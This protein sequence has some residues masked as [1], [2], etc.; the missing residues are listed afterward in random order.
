MIERSNLS[1]HEL[2]VDLLGVMSKLRYMFLILLLGS[3]SAKA[4][5][6]LVVTEQAPPLQFVVNNEVAGISTEIVK[7]VLKQA[8]W[9]VEILIYPWARSFD[10]AKKRKNTL[11]YSMMRNAER[12][13]D[14]HWIGKIGHFQL[15]FVAL[16]DNHDISISSLEDAKK[17]IIGTLRDD[18]THHFLTQ[19]HFDDKTQLLLRSELSEIL[20]LFFKRK[21]DTF[22]VDLELLCPLAQQYGYD[23]DKIKMLLPIPELAGDVYLGANIDS[24]IEDVAHLKKAFQIIKAKPQYQHGFSGG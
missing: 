5:E 24:D 6:W 22:V 20:D 18:Y 4:N 12:E 23:C 9:D 14:F 10:T 15:G 17:L 21:I 11:I 2:Q 8:Q 19:N 7:A 16:S 3:N 1:A 13:A